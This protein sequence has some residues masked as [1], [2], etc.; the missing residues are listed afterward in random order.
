MIK[1]KKNYCCKIQ[2]IKL[3][4]NQESQVLTKS[5]S[6]KT[7]KSN[8]DKKKIKFWPKK[9]KIPIVTN[10]QKFKLRQN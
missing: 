7:Q 2:N 5:N 9:N 10:I 1:F 4:Q 8:C 6:D 3:W